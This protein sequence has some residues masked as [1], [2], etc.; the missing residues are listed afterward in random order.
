MEDKPRWVVSGGGPLI[1]VPSEIAH[2]WRGDETTWPPTGDLDSIWEAVRSN[3]DYGRACGV[4]D[5]LGVLACGPGG[6]LILGDEPM[7]TTILPAKDGGLIVRWMWAESDDDVL[8]AVRS[9]PEGVWEATPHRFNLGGG[10]LLLFDSAYPGDDLPTTSEGADVPW[11]K[12]AVPSGTFEIDT[13]DYQ[14]DEQTRLILH[15]LRRS[16]PEIGPHRP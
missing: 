15:R 6:C 7:Q 3:S 2:H 8:R 5:Y 16:R 1:V 10:G 14:P 13:A 12:V 11:L 9:V 4:D